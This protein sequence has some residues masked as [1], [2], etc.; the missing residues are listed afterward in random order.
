MINYTYL[1]IMIIG[2]EQIKI[3]LIRGGMNTARS[4]TARSLP[5]LLD[6]FRHAFKANPDFLSRS[7]HKNKS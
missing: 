7:L 4:T 1:F 2:Q 3:S 6:R 5:Q